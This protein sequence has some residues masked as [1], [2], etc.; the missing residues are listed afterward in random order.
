MYL[1]HRAIAPCVELVHAP[2]PPRTPPAPPRTP[3]AAVHV[4]FRRLAADDLPL[5]HA[6]LNEPGVVRWWEGDDV[7]WPAVVRD[8]GPDAGGDVEHWLALLDD[9]PFGWIQ[10]YAIDSDP[11][12][13]G[14]WRARGVTSAA[15]GVDYL[16]GEPTERGR[17]LGAAML[18]AF[19]RDVAF[20]THPDW[21]HVGAAPDAANASSLRAL[22]RAGFTEVGPLDGASGAS[23]L[24]VVH[25]R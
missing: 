11:D 8:Y 14:A 6:W 16:V 5:L 25:R 24:M 19:V 10:A 22:R 18:R 12:E 9:R 13:A 20:P 23:I 1:H 15:G 21:H 17:G 2:E 4:R 7:S 3:P